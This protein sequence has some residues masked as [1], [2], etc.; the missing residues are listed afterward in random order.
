MIGW[1][2]I[3]DTGEQSQ[4]PRQV[5][6]PFNSSTNANSSARYILQTNVGP[7]GEDTCKGDSGWTLNFKFSS[8]IRI[9]TLTLH[10][11]TETHRLTGSLN[12]KP[13]G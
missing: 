1:G 4:F 9:F 10:D 6:L 11:Q 5:I 2:A 8:G 3:D 7:D 13:E 12:I